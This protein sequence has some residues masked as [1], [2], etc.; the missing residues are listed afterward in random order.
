[1]V[2]ASGSG[3]ARARRPLRSGARPGFGH[4]DFDCHVN[5]YA[6]TPSIVR[7]PNTA[8]CYPGG[9][10]L[11]KLSCIAAS[12]C[13]LSPDISHYNHAALKSPH[14]KVGGAPLSAVHKAFCFECG[15]SRCDKSLK[16]PPERCLYCKT[17]G[18]RGDFGYQRTNQES[19]IRIVITSRRGGLGDRL[20]FEGVRPQRLRKVHLRW[21]RIRARLRS[22]RKVVHL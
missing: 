5:R 19:I 6:K 13:A 11:R 21:F 3:F 18:G 7:R 9:S 8:L 20:V 10:I 2:S 16:T 22:R 14:S 4:F 15:F 12:A 1:V 17:D